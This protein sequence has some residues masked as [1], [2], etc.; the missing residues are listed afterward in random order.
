[1]YLFIYLK[2]GTVQEFWKKN[3]TKNKISFM[4]NSRADLSQGMLANIRFRISRLPVCYPKNIKIKRYR[5]IILP[6][7][8][9]G[10]EAWSFTFRDEYRLSV[11]ENRVLRRI[12]WPKRNEVTVEW[13]I[14]HREKLHVLCSSINI[15]RVSKS[16]RMRGTRGCSKY[17]GQERC[18]QGFS[19]ET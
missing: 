5:T 19:G 2:G 3:P 14:L 11:S 12:L 1:M 15:I 16:R 7:A 10:F 18:I 13:S 4:K 8:L 17:G 6:V 9:Y